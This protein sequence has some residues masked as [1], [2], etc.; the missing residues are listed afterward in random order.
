LL[1]GVFAASTPSVTEGLRA[2]GPNGFPVSNCA[3]DAYN[4][5]LSKSPPIED[6]SYFIQS[7]VEVDAV[8][9]YVQDVPNGIGCGPAIQDV[10]FTNWQ[11]TSRPPGS[12]AT[13]KYDRQVRRQVEAGHRGPVRHHFHGLPQP[14]HNRLPAERRRRRPA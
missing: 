1:I 7:T 2:Q 6:N 8:A 11:L 14:L 3:Y 10:P 9:N 4:V 13:L 12:S 5:Y